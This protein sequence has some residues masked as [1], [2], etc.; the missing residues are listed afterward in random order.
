MELFIQESSL[1]FGTEKALTPVTKRLRLKTKAI[2]VQ[3]AFRTII[4]SFEFI[5]SKIKAER[6]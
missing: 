1:H 5:Q 3:K 4:L 2:E 6:L